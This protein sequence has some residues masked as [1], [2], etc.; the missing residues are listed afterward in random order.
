MI[1]TD[2][3]TEGPLAT[4]T[5]DTTSKLKILQIIMWNIGMA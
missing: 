4:Q 2:V 5:V 1:M 3:Y